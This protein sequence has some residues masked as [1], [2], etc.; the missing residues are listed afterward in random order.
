VRT[1]DAMRADGGLVPRGARPAL[2]S[3]SFGSLLALRL[4]ARRPE[5]IAGAVLFG[6]YAD[7][8]D[9]IGF[10]L[11]GERRDP[12]NRP[13][14]FLNLLDLIDTGAADRA[15]LAAA[16][17]RYVRATWGRPEM[18][19]R[20]RWE[21][22][23]RAI[24]AELAAPARL[25]FLLGCGAEAGGDDVALDA[26][27]RLDTAYL[28]PRPQ[29]GAIRCPVDI[30]HGRDDDVIPSSHAER[31]AAALPAAARA[32]VHITGLYAHTGRAA[33]SPRAIARELATFARVV[34]LLARGR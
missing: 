15:E 26:L 13:V 8:A 7:F 3:I 19:E 10:C 4:A 22:V 20:A 17:R 32:R 25:L 9:A 16:W 23:A 34:R 12:L 24:A 27:A 29:L 5:Q 11:A 14:V 28:D 21:A 18:K 31:L 6:G 33:P 30:V 2:F 1:F